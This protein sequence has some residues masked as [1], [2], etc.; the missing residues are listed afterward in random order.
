M[1]VCENFLDFEQLKALM[2]TK[3]RNMGGPSTRKS[4][5]QELA[6]VFKSESSRVRGYGYGRGS[7]GG[8][9]SG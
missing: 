7:G 9:S 3:E 8:R 4:Y 5:Q 2:I 1:Y 6:P